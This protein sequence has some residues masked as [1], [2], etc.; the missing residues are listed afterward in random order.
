MIWRLGDFGDGATDTMA[1]SLDMS[2]GVVL[3][4]QE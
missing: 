2:Y 4:I 3:F 1:T